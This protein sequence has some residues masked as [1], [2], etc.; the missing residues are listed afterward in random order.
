MCWTAERQG[1]LRQT[2]SVPVQMGVGAAVV[3]LY[4]VSLLLLSPRR[5][6]VLTVVL[7]A[8]LPVLAWTVMTQAGWWWPG[9]GG[10]AHG[11]AGLSAVELAPARGQPGHD[12]ARDGAHGRAAASGRAQLE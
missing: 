7:A 9:G 12:D 3:V 4:L 8:G 6:L 11:A 5:A 1:L 2:V 10:G